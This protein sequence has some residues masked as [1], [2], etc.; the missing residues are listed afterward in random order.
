MEALQE[1]SHAEERQLNQIGK[2]R[3]RLEESSTFTRVSVSLLSVYL[4]LTVSFTRHRRKPA[5]K[6]WN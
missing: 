1:L 5:A 4:L 3:K 2:P 6:T